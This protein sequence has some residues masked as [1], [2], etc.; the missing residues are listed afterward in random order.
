M[1]RFNSSFLGPLS[2]GS[3]TLCSIICPL[4]VVGGNF[5]FSVSLS[6]VSAS[7]VCLDRL[8]TNVQEL[9]P[10]SLSLPFRLTYKKKRENLLQMG[11]RR[12]Y[13]HCALWVRR[14]NL[15]DG[16]V[17]RA[18]LVVVC[19]TDRGTVGCGARWGAVL[20]WSWQVGWGLSE[21]QMSAVVL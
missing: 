15:M 11:K 10:T 9:S 6:T 17:W 16:T 5:V 2:S 14:A 8:L 1:I 19:L 12:Q 13:W 3:V 21:Y 18:A 7:S 20:G 4:L